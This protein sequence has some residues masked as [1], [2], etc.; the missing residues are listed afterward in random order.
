MLL[1][2]LTTPTT[3][4]FYACLLCFIYQ[5]VYV[6]CICV[7]INQLVFSYSLPKYT[8]YATEF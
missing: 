6:G 3:S 4:T 8:Q 1:H 2:E 7:P 5:L